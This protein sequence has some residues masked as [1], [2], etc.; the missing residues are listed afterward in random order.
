MITKGGFQLK[1]KAKKIDLDLEL[2][3]LTGEVAELKGP[4][5]SGRE[6]GELANTMNNGGMEFDKLPE[7]KRTPIEAG[8]MFGAQLAW[9]YP[10]KAPDWWV[11]NLDITTIKEVRNHVIATLLGVKKKET[12]G[13]K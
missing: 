12:S 4:I 3:T 10:E 6:A 11:D 13:E 5:F 8:L 1:F 2:T 7:E 9:V